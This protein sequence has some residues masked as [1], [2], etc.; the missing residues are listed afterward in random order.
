[1]VNIPP[2]VRRLGGT[3]AQ[4]TR[5]WTGDTKAW[6][7]GIAVLKESATLTLGESAQVQVLAVPFVGGDTLGLS[8]VEQAGLAGGSSRGDATT[9]SFGEAAALVVGV[10]VTDTANL[11]L[12][13]SVLL[14]ARSTLEDSGGITIEETVS[15]V[16]GE[17]VTGDT[18]SLPLDET[19]VVASCVDTS[20]TL[21]M[22]LEGRFQLS[23]VF[24]P[25]EGTTS[26][27]EWREETKQP[28]TVWVLQVESLDSG[29]TKSNNL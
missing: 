27:S 14:A 20:D 19:P 1:M 7:S 25:Q 18:L 26:P 24:W 28:S 8:L 4:A 29:F 3:W 15:G 6:G 17:V 16:Y 23:R 11:A 10:Q 22:Q 5:P 13:A 2:P 21:T 9:V 12:A